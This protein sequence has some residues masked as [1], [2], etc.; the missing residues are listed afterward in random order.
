MQTNPASKKK[1]S[2]KKTSTQTGVWDNTPV[3]ENTSSPCA[4]CLMQMDLQRQ[5][6]VLEMSVDTNS[7]KT[8]KHLYFC[9]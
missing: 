7:Y 6:Y 3:P 8:F 9:K 5:E 2:E 1:K 4:V